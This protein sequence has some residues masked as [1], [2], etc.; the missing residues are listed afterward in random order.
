MPENRDACFYRRRV[1][2]MWFAAHNSGAYVSRSKIQFV[3]THPVVYMAWG[4]HASYPIPG[5]VG[6]DFTGSGYQWHARLLLKPLST[7][8]WRNFSG[9]WGEVGFS[10][11]TTGPLGPWH[12]RRGR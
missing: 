1:I 5:R 6:Y 10:T 12:K 3:G 2:G 4:T 11:H 9:A 8:P 7:Q